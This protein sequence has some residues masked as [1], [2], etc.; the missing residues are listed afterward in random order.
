MSR[1]TLLL[2]AIAACSVSRGWAYYLPGVYPQN[3]AEGEVYVRRS[4]CVARRGQCLGGNDSWSLA[5]VS[6]APLC[7][8]MQ[9]SGEGGQTVKYCHASPIRIL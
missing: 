8:A 9:G 6:P 5:R 1:A 7:V 4:G 2:L 3:F